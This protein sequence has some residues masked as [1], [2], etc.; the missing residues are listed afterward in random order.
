LNRDILAGTRPPGDFAREL[1]GE[2]LLGL[3][4]PEV[5]SAPQARQLVVL[6]GLAG[7]SVG[8]HY[9]EED[10]AH[11]ATPAQAFAH[12][13]VGAAGT[14][15]RD[16]FAQLAD[17]TDT[18]HC[19]RD[20]F[21]S[22]VRWNL[23][24]SEVHWEG[25]RIAVLPSVF[26]D[27]QIR[28]YTGT[29]DEMRFFEL[30]K[31]S[32][33]LELAVNATLLPLSDGTVDLLG[34]NAL[35]RVALAVALMTA[36]RRLSTIF[37]ALPPEDGLRPDYFLDVF[38]QYAVPWE[39]GDIPPSGALDPEWI[40]RDLLLGLPFGGHRTHI[41][42]LL[43]AL[44]DTERAAVLRLMSRASLPEL[45]LRA[46]GLD[47]A[48]LAE[49]PPAGR[50]Q[51]A[52]RHPILVA[53]YLLLNAHARMSGVHLRLSKK[54]LFDPQRQREDAG[55]GDPG[56]VSNRQGTTGMDERYLDSL[57]K[58]RHRHVLA[59]LHAVPGEELDLLAVV[60]VPQV[61][62]PADLRDLVRFAQ[63]TIDTA[64]VAVLV[65]PADAARGSNDGNTGRP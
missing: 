38:R 12:L 18:G 36:L 42:H 14:P 29:P 20:T 33:T 25:A 17:R 56:V 43:P 31:L 19:H 46:L 52:A 61:Q 47:P 60:G 22:L 24:T 44:L 2:V 65:G 63:P 39:A 59:F 64:R 6:L 26:D 23:P 34:E 40:Q 55:L 3:P 45:A 53:L 11:R 30:L 9:Q 21:A 7:A 35:R 62:A 32:E 50:R 41:R 27:G 54:F 8:R 49:L 58:A 13:V 16:Y 5:F 28:T 57:T 48:M 10:A 4:A 1:T 15:F 37:A 51:L